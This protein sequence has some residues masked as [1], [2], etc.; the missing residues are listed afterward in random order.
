MC[1]VGRVGYAEGQGE[2]PLG[3]HLVDWKLTRRALVH[4]PSRRA[5]CPTQPYELIRF[6]AIDVTKLYKLIWSGDIHGPKT[7]PSQRVSVDVHVA[8]TGIIVGLMWEVVV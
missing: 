4:A 1:N 6:G 3:N 5:T 2:T 7:L 8:D